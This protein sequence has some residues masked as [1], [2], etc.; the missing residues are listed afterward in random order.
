M[1]R[2]IINLYGTPAQQ[3]IDP[4]H[5][6]SIGDQIAIYTPAT[7][8][9]FVAMFMAFIPPASFIYTLPL[10][11]S[12]YKV[13]KSLAVDGVRGLASLKTT[14]LLLLSLYQLL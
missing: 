12:S 5:V 11:E 7:N 3:I 8:G 6:P 13:T 2:L 10:P 9:V 14:D 1:T 4:T